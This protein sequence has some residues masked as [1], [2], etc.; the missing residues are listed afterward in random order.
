MKP[1]V[2][3]LSVPV[4]FQ[5]AKPLRCALIALLFFTA[6]VSMNAAD[7]ATAYDAWVKPWAER[8]ATSP[9]LGD[10]GLK[11]IVSIVS[12]EKD[13][14]FVTNMTPVQRL[15]LAYHI[16]VSASEVS[17]N[18]AV[19]SY[20]VSNSDARS[21]K[22]GQ[23]STDDFQKLAEALAKLPDDLS[24]LPPAGRRVVV[25]VWEN[26]RWRVRVYDGNHLPPEVKAVL[27]LLANPFDKQA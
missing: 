2:E 1:S 18:G 5:P 12:G 24:Q 26:D 20:F 23:L 19:R 8:P 17:T 4:S 25:Q 27:E 14:S 21:G 7:S 16:N 10:A 13:I 9:S 11:V 15:E 3:P 22:V 6:A